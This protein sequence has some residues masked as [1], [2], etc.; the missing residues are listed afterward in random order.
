MSTNSDDTVSL[1][2]QLKNDGLVNISYD[3]RFFIIQRDNCCARL[4]FAVDDVVACNKPLFDD[5][6]CNYPLLVYGA[7]TYPLLRDGAHTYPLLGYGAC[8]HPLLDDGACTY[9]LI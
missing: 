8:T 7:C 6:V 5:G 2:A 1:L 9:T 3:L 4:T